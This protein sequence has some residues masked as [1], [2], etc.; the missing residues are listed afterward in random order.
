M[1]DF[2][3]STVYDRR[4]PK[5]KF[6][7]NLSVTPELKRIFVEQINLISWKN[8]LAPSTI[9]VEAGADVTEIEVIEIR[10]NQQSLDKRV[11]RLIDREIPYHILFVLAYEGKAQAWIAY[12]ESSRAKSGTFKPGV[13]YH[14]D[15]Q[16][17]ETLTLR[18]EGLNMDSVYE[19]F[20]RQIAG[21]RLN[22]QD[23][24]IKEAVNR[25]ERRQ[26]LMKEITALE[27]KVRREKQFNRQV[28]INSEV[29][30]LRLEL[31]ELG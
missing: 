17:P 2:P 12:K 7:E 31:E 21:D 3:Q 18:L 25:D 26:K 16:P 9:N 29:K 24:E 10:L 27:K 11:L 1:L 5:Q 20:V 30:R 28:E 8:K 14:T 4:I 13:Y 6:Y 19:G 22:N 23:S 15:W